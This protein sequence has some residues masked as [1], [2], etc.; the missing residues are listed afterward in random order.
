MGESGG[1]LRRRENRW[2]SKGGWR[3]RLSCTGKKRGWRVVVM[4]GQKREAE[5]LDSWVWNWRKKYIYILFRRCRR[6][7]RVTARGGASL[8]SNTTRIY[9]KTCFFSASI[10]PN[11]HG[12]RAQTLTARTFSPVGQLTESI[13]CSARAQCMQRLLLG[14]QICAGR[15]GGMQDGCV[16]ADCVFLCKHLFAC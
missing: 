5:K 15:E 11:H 12:T 2:N 13:S 4:G 6:N 7:H 3:R 1:D 8:N 16:R 10:H 14:K 9:L